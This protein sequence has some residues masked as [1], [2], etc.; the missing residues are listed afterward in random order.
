[1]WPNLLRDR[2]PG[3]VVA[4]STIAVAVIAAADRRINAQIPLALL[5][6]LPAAFAGAGLSRWQVPIFGVFCTIVA[7]L[8]D[9]FP[10]SV[11]QGIP[12]DALYFSAYTAAGLYVSEM[13]ANRRLERDHLHAVEIEAEARLQAEEQLRLLVATS[14]IAIVT[15]DEHGAILH[16]NEAAERLLS[17]EETQSALRLKGQSLAHYLPALARAPVRGQGHRQLKTMMQCQGVRADLEPF[18]ADVWFSTYTTHE[19]PRMTAMII[20]SSKDLRDRE[21]ANL[22]QVLKGSRLLVGAVSHEI[23]NICGAIGL[24]MQNLLARSA[25]LEAQQDFQALGQ[26]TSALERLASV[27]LSHVKRQASRVH[28]GRFL[29]DLRIIVGPSLRDSG[30][31]VHW[32]PSEDLPTVWADQQSLL[33]V[34]LNLIRNSEAALEGVPHPELSLSVTRGDAAVQVRIADNGPGVARPELLFHPFRVEG[35]ASPADQG[36]QPGFGLYLSRAMVS[37]F[38]GELRYEPSTAGAVFVVELLPVDLAKAAP[39][40]AEQESIHV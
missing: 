39:S 22:E 26:L 16:A 23:R 30:V 20:D 12:R 40:M 27:E 6:V 37:G 2:K 5:Y 4:V 21:E 32:E 24:V 33:Q 36:G 1:M 18:F 29:R 34:F 11:F 14:S 7:E 9:A 25:K 15:S 38:R 3:L 19:G 17:G 10:W 31:Q 8:A 13:L 28:L 35:G